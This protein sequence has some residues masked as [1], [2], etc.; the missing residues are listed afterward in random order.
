MR[1]TQFLNHQLLPAVNLK[2]FYLT[3]F[4]FDPVCAWINLRPCNTIQLCT[5][6]WF[7]LKRIE[8]LWKYMFFKIKMLSQ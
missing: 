6:F 8:E 7:E 2:T 5:V 4:C 3:Q 1:A